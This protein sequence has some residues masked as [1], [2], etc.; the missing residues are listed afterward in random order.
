MIGKVKNP[1][2]GGTP[3]GFGTETAAGQATVSCLYLTID[4]SSR[5]RGISSYLPQGEENAIRSSELAR[6]TGAKSVRELQHWVAAERS[7]GALILSTGKGGYFL[8]AEGEKGQAEIARFVATLRSR[9]VNT[10][11]ALK[12]AKAALSKTTEQITMDEF[13]C[14]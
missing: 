9:A 3:T 1:G 11:K 12:T 10:L 13:E 14:L 6:I 5:Q 2:G 7:E 8:P 4:E